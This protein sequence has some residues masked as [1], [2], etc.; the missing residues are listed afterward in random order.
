LNR[1]RAEV[2]SSP[3]ATQA[4]RVPRVGLGR[5]EH[6]GDQPRLILRGERARRSEDRQPELGPRPRRQPRAIGTSFERAR[7]LLL[8]S[9]E[10][11]RLSPM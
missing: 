7:C 4:T 2:A 6:R 8:V 5:R 3:L 10:Q 11:R 1:A 9:L